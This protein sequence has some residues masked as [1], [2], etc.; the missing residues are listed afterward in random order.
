MEELK[1]TKTES[2][3][4]AWTVIVTDGEREEKDDGTLALGHRALNYSEANQV[5]CYL[6]SFF[7][8]DES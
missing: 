1:V 3:A 7:D 4:G 5:E 2:E 8:E 6:R